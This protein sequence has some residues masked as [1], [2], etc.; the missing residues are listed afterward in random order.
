MPRLRSHPGIPSLRVKRDDCTGRAFGGNK[1]RKL[2]FNLA[3]SQT[4]GADCVVS[5]GVAQSNTARQVAAA[6]AK[7]SIE[8]HLGIMH[9]RPR[10]TEPGYEDTGTSFSTASL[11]RS[12]TTFPG[13]IAETGGCRPSH[14]SCRPPGAACI[15]CQMARQTPWV[16][17]VMC[18]PRWRSSG[19]VRTFVGSSTPP[20]SAGTQSGLAAGLLAFSHPC[21]VIGIDGDADADRIRLDVQRSGRDTAALLGIEKHWADGA[22]EAAGDWCGPADGEPDASTEESI[23]LAAGLE[24]L[25]V[26]PVYSGK[27]TAGLSR[28][29]RFRDSGP[30]V[31]FHGP[32]DS[33]RPMT[34]PVHGNEPGGSFPALASCRIAVFAITY[35][36]ATRLL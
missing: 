14:P 11:E 9:G 5:G 26:D 27:G 20:G 23:L 16:R 19:T 2:E 36:L 32:C 4:A 1:V 31:W 13:T 29:G 10:N 28:K 15:L 24:G 30:A 8:C 33:P 7:I 21:G 3:A 22:V 18:L 34:Q 17:S 12:S 25:A 6:C 35:D